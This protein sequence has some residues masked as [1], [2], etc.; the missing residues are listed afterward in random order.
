ME[1]N[2]PQMKLTACRDVTCEPSDPTREREKK[3]ARSSLNKGVENIQQTG[4]SHSQICFPNPK[5]ALPW[6][7]C[8]VFS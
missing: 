6:F 1:L 8:G 2:I 3:A 7:S 5:P 4:I